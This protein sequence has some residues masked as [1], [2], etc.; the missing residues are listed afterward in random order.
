[1]PNHCPPLT[2][3]LPSSA[4]QARILKHKTNYYVCLKVTA[5]SDE[6]EIKYNYLRL[7]RLV[8]PD[9]CSAEGAG[10]ASAV[11]N[12]S[13]DTLMNPLKKTLYDAYL[14]DA[15]KGTEGEKTYA[16]WEASNAMRPVQIPAWLQKVLEIK[17]LGQVVALLLV[18]ILIPLLLIAVVIA[19]VL[20]LVCLPINILLKCF[21]PDKW[22]KMKEQYEEDLKRAEQGEYQA[23]SQNNM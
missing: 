8:H 6:A 9:K 21:C 3:S 14:D 10:E 13:K 1:M 7:S 2:H 23:P 11:L 15:A 19:F 12:Q 4:R 16:E 20:W 22:E 18:I 17:V 5:D